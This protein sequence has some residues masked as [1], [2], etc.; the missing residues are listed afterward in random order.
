VPELVRLELTA[1]QAL[2]LFEWL[3]RTDDDNALEAHIEHW[4]EQLALWAVLA[5]LQRI[6]IEPLDP[7]YDELLTAAR[8]RMVFGIA[9]SDRR[10]PEVG[11]S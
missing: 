10:R 11:P 8:D 4:S 2:V 5:Q 1:D 6:L 7:K 3:S 9:E